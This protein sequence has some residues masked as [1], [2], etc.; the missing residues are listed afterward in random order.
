MADS[1]WFIVDLGYELS[2]A[3]NYEPLAIQTRP[4]PLPLQAW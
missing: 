3:M 4:L 2:F 1:S